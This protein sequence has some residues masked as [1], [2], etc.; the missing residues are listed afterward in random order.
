MQKR[1]L[2]MLLLVIMLLSF[3]AMPALAAEE[4]TEPVDPET[5]VAVEAEDVVEPAEDPVVPPEEA[6]ET[7]EEAEETPGEAEETPEEAEETVDESEETAEV[8]AEEIDLRAATYAAYADYFEDED[9]FNS[10]WSC[11]TGPYG[12]FK[13]DYAPKAIAQA[14]ADGE[15]SMYGIIFKDCSTK[16]ETYALYAD[17][18]LDEETFNQVWFSLTGP[19]GRLTA[20]ENERTVSAIAQAIAD[21]ETELNGISFTGRSIIDEIAN[22]N[23]EESVPEGTAPGTGGYY[24]LDVS[25]W[26]NA[27]NVYQLSICTGKTVTSEELQAENE[28]HAALQEE[29]AAKAAVAALEAENAE[30][31]AAETAGAAAEEAEQ[32]EA[33]A[34][35]PDTYSDIDEI[36]NTSKDIIDWGDGKLGGYYSG[37]FE[38]GLDPDAWLAEHPEWADAPLDLDESEHF[39][40]VNAN[41]WSS[42]DIAAAVAAL[43]AENAE[44]YAAEPKTAYAE[45]AAVYAAEPAPVAE[46]PAVAE[47]V[48]LDF[49]AGKCIA[50]QE[51]C[52]SLALWNARQAGFM[53]WTQ[54]ALPVT[55][56]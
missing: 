33:A 46:E 2:S 49:T 25:P 18:F 47:I 45:P 9:T 6:E 27:L 42:E 7:P 55:A 51:W 11:L 36:Y 22:A 35:E 34:S 31:Y 41:L 24:T 37:D 39:S 56:L 32:P 43:E 4:V 14:I 28:R 16:E 26:V 12:R 23:T 38:P 29:E 8:P 19:K 48:G 40:E 21:G 50:D 1:L 52:M 10:I 5:P 30:L 54:A 17:H 53:E 20:A 15:T 3:A 13:E 44:L